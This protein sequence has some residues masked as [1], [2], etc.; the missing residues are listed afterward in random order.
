MPILRVL[1]AP[2]LCQFPLSSMD[3]L[4]VLKQCRNGFAGLFFLPKGLFIIALLHIAV[5]IV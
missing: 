2:F 4:M 5:V 1:M 3:H